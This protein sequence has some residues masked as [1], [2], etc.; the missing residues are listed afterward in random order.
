VVSF[1]VI[2]SKEML[3]VAHRSDMKLLAVVKSEGPTKIL[4]ITPSLQNAV[5]L[6]E[7]QYCTNFLQEQIGLLQVRNHIN[8]V[9]LSV[10]LS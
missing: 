6:R 8:H 7:M 10:L 9:F 4:H 2:G 5:M 3:S 1:D